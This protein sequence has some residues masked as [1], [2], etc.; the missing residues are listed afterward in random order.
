MEQPAGLFSDRFD[1]FGHRVPGHRGQDAAEEVEVIAAF[2]V[3]HHTALTRDQLDRFVVV[4]RD[5]GGQDPAV[6][7]EQVG[8]AH[9]QPM[10]VP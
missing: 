5:P 10:L 6:A 3:G 2:G 1:N 4:E 8:M 7:L 9:G